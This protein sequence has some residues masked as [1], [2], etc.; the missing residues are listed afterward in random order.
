MLSVLEA[1]TQ[2]AKAVRQLVWHSQT[3]TVQV[4]HSHWKLE[5]G[6]WPELVALLE[7]LVASV[8]GERFWSGLAEA[9]ARATSQRWGP[10]LACHV[11]LQG[12]STSTSASPGQWSQWW[13]GSRFPGIPSC[14][15][16]EVRS[17]TWSGWPRMWRVV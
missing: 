7:E 5:T 9:M 2:L 3:D 12:G 15:R 14:C 10:G 6:H 16:Y 11:L 8:Q 4:L 13:V 1:L 17:S